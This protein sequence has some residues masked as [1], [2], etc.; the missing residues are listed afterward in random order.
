MGGALVVP[1]GLLARLKGKRDDLPNLF[2]R[3]TK[4]IEQMAMRAVMELERS[5]KYQPRDVSQDNCGYDIESTIP[6]S[7][8]LR[9]IEV[10]GRLQ[11]AKTVTVT[12]NEILTALNKPDGF[13]LGIAL[14]PPTEE[15]QSA[16]FR[17]TGGPAGKYITTHNGCQVY[18]VRRPFAKEP[19]FGVTSVNYNL[20]KLFAKSDTPS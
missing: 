17:Q 14:V 12:K 13:I 8:K 19:D 1:A 16:D 11:G 4:R 2:A 9:F 10:K 20:L 6:D 15:S 7:G 18:Y 3:E 5:L